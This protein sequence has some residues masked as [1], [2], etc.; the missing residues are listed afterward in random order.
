MAMIASTEIADRIT[1]VKILADALIVGVSIWTLAITATGTEN[2][3]VATQ[4]S[5]ELG[6]EVGHFSGVIRANR[7]VCVRH[8]KVQVLRTQSHQAVGSDRANARGRYS[9][10]SDE[11]SGSWFAK[12]KPK[13]IAGTFCKGARSASYEAG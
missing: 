1:A 7:E 9:V 10:Q 5:L 3:R 12:V 13:T 8:R 4:V 6:P 11:V 2:K